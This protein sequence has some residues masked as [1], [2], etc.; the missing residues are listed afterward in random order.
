MSLGKN[1]LKSRKKLGLSQEQLGEKIKVSRQTISNWELGQ[2]SPNSEQLKLISKELNVSV[3]ELLNNENNTE[4]KQQILKTSEDTKIKSNLWKKIFLILGSPIWL[5]LLIALFSILLSIY[6]IL[7]SVIVCLW[8]IF[9]SILGFALAMILSGIP[10]TFDNNILAG[11]A[12]IS[13]G[14]ICTGL[15]ILMFIGCKAA[16]KAIIL[17]TKKL[18]YRLKTIFKKWRVYNG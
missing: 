17:V 7:W 1:I 16:T 5:S 13:A 6:I 2:T 4:I 12:M 10:F 3:D 18:F 11:V 9:G 8:A 15:S 14:I